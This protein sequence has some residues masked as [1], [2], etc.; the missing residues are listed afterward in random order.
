MLRRIACA[1]TVLCLGFGVAL[2][3]EMT[4]VI[5]KIDKDKLTFREGKKGAE[6]KTYDVAADV[7]VFRFV[8]KTQKELDPDGLKAEPLPNLPK[9]GVLAVINVV[10]GKV[11]EI[12]IPAKKKK[13]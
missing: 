10:D 13:N 3:D 5:D 8:S 1:V 7:K 2:A 4:G 12:S 9:G 6:A 11:T